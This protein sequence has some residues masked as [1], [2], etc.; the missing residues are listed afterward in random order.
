MGEK[1]EVNKKINF[2]CSFIA[3]N[4][5]QTILVLKKILEFFSQ[6]FGIFVFQPLYCLGEK[7]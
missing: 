5:F 2:E 3:Q 4:P 7:K 1:N 6:K